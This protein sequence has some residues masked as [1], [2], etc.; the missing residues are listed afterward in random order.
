MTLTREEKLKLG[1][2]H[3]SF[4]SGAYDD[5]VVNSFPRFFFSLKMRKRG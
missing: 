4:E 5:G 3:V 2:Q 1:R